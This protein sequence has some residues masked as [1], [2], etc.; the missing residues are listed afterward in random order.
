MRKLILASALSWLIIP[1]KSHRSPAA[2]FN[3]EEQKAILWRLS[4]T[5]MPSKQTWT[6]Q[7]GPWVAS[8]VSTNTLSAGSHMI[9]PR[10]TSIGC[11][12]NAQAKSSDEQGRI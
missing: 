5:G 3:P 11:G 10:K 9:E 1:A 6:R 12:C 8:F 2:P 4:R 7:T